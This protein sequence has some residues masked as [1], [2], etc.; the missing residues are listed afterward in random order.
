MIP[1]AQLMHNTVLYENGGNILRTN[2]ILKT[3]LQQGPEVNECKRGVV[4]DIIRVVHA[5]FV[6]FQISKVTNVLDQRGYTVHG[7]TALL[8]RLNPHRASVADVVELVEQR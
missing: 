7:F 1:Q 8:G 5:I 2:I 3:K 6:T 4:M